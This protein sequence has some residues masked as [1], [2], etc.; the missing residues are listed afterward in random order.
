VGLRPAGQPGADLAGQARAW[1]EVSCKAQGVPVKVND[2]KVL[3][4]AAELLGKG[5]QEAA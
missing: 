5:R 1:V 2:P 4:A 3:G